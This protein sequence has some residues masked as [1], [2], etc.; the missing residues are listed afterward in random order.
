MLFSQSVS[1]ASIRRD[2]GDMGLMI[3]ES[4]S[5][6]HRAIGSSVFLKSRAAARDPYRLKTELRL[7]LTRLVMIWISRSARDFRGKPSQMARSPD[8]P[9]ARFPPGYFRVY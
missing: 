2:W 3:K 4:G 8:D 1:S 6:G 5:S 9:M 7:D